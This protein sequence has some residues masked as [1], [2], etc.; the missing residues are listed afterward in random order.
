MSFSDYLKMPVSFRKI[1]SSYKEK[2]FLMLDVGCGNHSA[3][4]AKKY[5]PECQY[6]GLDKDIYNNDDHDFNLMTKFYKLDLENNSLDI[7]PDNFFDVV[8]MNHVIEHINNGV[9][10]VENISKKIKSSGIIYIETPSVRSLSLPSQPGTLNFCDDETH[11]KLYNIIDIANVLLRNNFKIIKAGTRRDKVGM[12]F[13]PYFILKKI[14]KKEGLSGFSVW[15][16]TGFAW[17][18]YAKKLNNN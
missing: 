4:V 7:I 10:V 8:I 5:F 11:K 1:Y 13:S 2:K 17:F 3:T 15:D 9:E 12:F 16:I 18:I 14:I 6:Y